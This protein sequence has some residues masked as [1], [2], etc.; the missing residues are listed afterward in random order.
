MMTM[1]V[2]TADCF[3][4]ENVGK[5]SFQIGIFKK[6]FV[7]F[8]LQYNKNNNMIEIKPI[9]ISQQYFSNWENSLKSPKNPFHSTLSLSV[10]LR[11]EIKEILDKS[12]KY[13]RI[14]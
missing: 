4:L 1:M 14:C 12:S 5:Q 13:C 7:T 10:K 9:I 3:D 2:I 11:H 8:V 6:S